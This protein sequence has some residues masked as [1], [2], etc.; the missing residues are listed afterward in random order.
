ITDMD[1]SGPMAIEADTLSSLSLLTDDKGDD[2]HIL[3]RSHKRVRG[4]DEEDD[5]AIIPSVYTRVCFSH[6]V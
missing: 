6:P 5:E 1:N 2:A 4:N 3:P